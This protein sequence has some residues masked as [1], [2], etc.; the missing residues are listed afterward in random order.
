MISAEE[1]IGMIAKAP[2]SSRLTN[3][4]QCELINL[5]FEACLVLTKPW[6]R[7]VGNLQDDNDRRCGSMEKEWT[8]TLA[9]N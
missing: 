2:K 5:L 6:E 3:I 9:E 1:K 8:K 4:H 7:T